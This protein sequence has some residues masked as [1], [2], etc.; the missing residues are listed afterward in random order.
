MLRFA[1]SF[2][3]K[4]GGKPPSICVQHVSGRVMVDPTRNLNYFG[5]PVNEK[6][7]TKS[8]RLILEKTASPALKIVLVVI[9]FSSPERQIICPNRVSHRVCAV[10]AVP[11]KSSGKPQSHVT[12][13][14]LSRTA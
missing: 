9:L 11:M 2:F 10:V 12:F 6:F 3:G 5:Q 14:G 8:M 13:C 1:P 7:S 4:R